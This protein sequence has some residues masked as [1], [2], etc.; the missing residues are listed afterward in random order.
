MNDPVALDDAQF[1][2]AL[3]RLDALVALGAAV[4]IE[5]Y[6]ALCPH[7]DPERDARILIR[8]VRTMPNDGRWPGGPRDWR[9]AVGAVSAGALACGWS[10]ARLSA[11]MVR[12]T[13]AH[14]LASMLIDDASDTASLHELVHRVAP[15]LLASVNHDVMA[16]VLTQVIGPVNNVTVD[17]L[18]LRTMLPALEALGVERD[19]LARYAI[20][21]LDTRLVGVQHHM[22][23]AE[24]QSAALS[25]ETR[26]SD[27][28]IALVTNTALPR[29]FQRGM[30]RRFGRRW[31]L[32]DH[33]LQALPWL[34]V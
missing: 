33:G 26:W 34:F 27:V 18:R 12:A 10:W 31:R 20:R 30:R 32:G 13:H 9:G 15:G 17:E 23:R 24:F 7:P 6:L 11:A 14:R 1:R 19:H 28:V 4:D 16:I 22:T 3:E 8:A 25:P 21:W 29:W 2:D 5:E